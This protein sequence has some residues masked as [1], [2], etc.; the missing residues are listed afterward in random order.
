MT[1]EV[2]HPGARRGEPDSQRDSLGGHQLDALEEGGVPLDEVPGAGE[3]AGPSEQQL[4]AV[5]RRGIVAKQS[6][7]P[8]NQRAALSGARWTVS[9]PAWCRVAT[10]SW[11]PFRPERSTWWARSEAVAPLEA[12]ADAL[13]SWARNRHP[14]GA[15][16]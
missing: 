16:S 11:S 7:R 12:R 10:A 4:D 13:S 2:L 3:G 8:P 14:A 5:L 1:E 9:S 15:V 6:Q